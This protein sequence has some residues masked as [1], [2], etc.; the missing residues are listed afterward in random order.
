MS[1]NNHHEQALRVLDVL[2][3][4]LMFVCLML[5]AFYGGLFL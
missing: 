3:F 4:G 2:C 5:L 1:A